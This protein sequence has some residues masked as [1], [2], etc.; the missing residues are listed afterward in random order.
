AE[1]QHRFPK[2]A[3]AR[4]DLHPASG[5]SLRPKFQRRARYR[6]GRGRDLRWADPAP[7]G[8]RPGE[9]RHDRSRTAQLIAIVKMV[10]PRV[11]EVARELH[12]PEPEDAAVEIDIGLRVTA[13]GGD[14]VD[15]RDRGAHP[16]L[17]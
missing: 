1:A 2:A 3:P 4:G 10:A 5:Q 7:G 17:R 11:I 12:Q 14:V 9:E 15:T 16:F 13:D 6:E 8:A